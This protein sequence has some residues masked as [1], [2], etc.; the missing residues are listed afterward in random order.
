MNSFFS[1]FKSQVDAIKA[2]AGVYWEKRGTQSF[3]Q[4]TL[5]MLTCHGWHIMVLF[6]IGKIVY[7]IKVPILSHLLKVIFQIIWFL[8]TT[9]YG[10]WLDLTNNIGKGFYIGHFGGIIVRGDFGDYCSI[11]QCVTVGTKGAGRSDGYPVIGKEVYIGAGAKVIG[12]I[13][14]GDGV[15]IG[16]NAVVTKSIESNCLAIGIPSKTRAL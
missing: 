15:V 12:N 5:Y 11:G 13:K 2:D 7:A 1:A 8:F 14:I 9:I 6:R 10:I 4:S 3:L 16:A